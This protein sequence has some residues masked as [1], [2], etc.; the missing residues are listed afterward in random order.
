RPA[1]W[2][3]ALLPWRSAPPVCGARG[4]TPSGPLPSLR[5][6]PSSDAA[7]SRPSRSPQTA[8]S[9][10]TRG[11]RD[12]GQP[13]LTR[14]AR[15]GAPGAPSRRRARRRPRRPSRAV[16]GRPFPIAERERRERLGDSGLA[17]AVLADDDGHVGVE[18]H[19]DVVEAANVGEEQPVEPGHA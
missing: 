9:T 16:R 2:P 6:P 1:P 8:G 14:V 4:G 3:I 5:P 13:A 7:P 11:R 19:L 12:G 15:R 10:G 18:R 17:G